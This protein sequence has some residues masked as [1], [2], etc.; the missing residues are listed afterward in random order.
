MT[1]NCYCLSESESGGAA[2]LPPTDGDPGPN[3]EAHQ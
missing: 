1:R 2:F 3:D